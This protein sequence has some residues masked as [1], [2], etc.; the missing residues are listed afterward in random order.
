M[1]VTLKDIAT[2]L[3]YSV[4]TVSRALRNC[5][6]I[7]PVT[8]D[9]IRKKADEMG[10]ISNQ[11]AQSLRSGKSKTIAVLVGSIANPHFSILINEMEE[12]AAAVGYTLLILNTHED[13]QTEQ[14]AIR[15]AISQN[16]DG[17]LLCPSQRSD[18]NYRIMQ[19]NRMPF[20]LFGR[21]D[22]RYPYVLA[23]DVK[24]GY[25]ATNELIRRG[26]RH[27]AFLNAPLH[28]SSA[29]DRL[30]GYQQAMEEAGLPVRDNDIFTPQG[31]NGIAKA[32]REKQFPPN[33]TTATFCFCDLFACEYIYALTE[34][35]HRVPEDMSVIG[36]DNIQS[37]MTLPRRIN[38]IQNGK[39][40]L[41]K[42]SVDLLMQQI[43]G[44]DTLQQIVLDVS[45]TDG[46]TVE[47]CR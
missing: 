40:L 8:R 36:V 18:E 15:T 41:A 13:P 23:D 33:G 22:E 4:N 14:N 37:R 34:M 2:E 11:S 35:G 12:H 46:D 24:A 31:K 38:S 19:T 3:G 45:P 29:A 39:R 7:P 30:A 5:N 20:V 21:R 25:L 6:D 27:I 17:I 1:G 9:K 10:Y 26:H 28:I 16:V 47:V 42:T 32:V 43:N 44:N